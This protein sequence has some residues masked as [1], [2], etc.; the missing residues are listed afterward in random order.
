MPSTVLYRAMQCRRA[1]VFKLLM[2]WPQFTCRG[3]RLLAQLMKF[4]SYLVKKLHILTNKVITLPL[5]WWKLNVNHHGISRLGKW[6]LWRYNE[7]LTLS[8]LKTVAVAQFRVCILRGLRLKAN[9]ITMPREGCPSS[10]APPNAAHKCGLLLLLF[11]GCTATILCG[12][13]YPMILCAPENEE[14]KKE[15]GN[16]A[17]RRSSLFVR[18]LQKLWYKGGNVWWHA[19]KAWP[20]HLTMVDVAFEGLSEGLAFKNCKGCVLQKIQTL[21]WDTA[22]D[23]LYI[24]LKTQNVAY[25]HSGLYAWHET[26]VTTSPWATKAL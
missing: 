5:V 13:P 21:N 17:W 11:G 1:T 19:P 15:N 25:L 23:F 8:I 24:L 26:Q 12:L 4:S 6:M 22:S 7:K 18:V 2:A 3:C 9:Y 14:K 16:F 10:K 20:S